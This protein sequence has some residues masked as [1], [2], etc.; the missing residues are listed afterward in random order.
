MLKRGIWFV[1]LFC[2]SLIAPSALAQTPMAVEV[3][4]PDGLV[5][6]G[7]WYPLSNDRPTILLLHQMYTNRTSWQPYIGI[8]TGAGYNVLAVDVRGHGQT[9]GK[10]D[11]AK[12]VDD[13]AVWLGW[14][15][16]AG[17]RDALMTMGSSM[18][19]TL[20]IVGCARDVT[21]RTA[22]AIS[23]GWSYNGISVEESLTTLLAG[24][25]VLILYTQRD[26][27][28]SRGVPRM[29]AA[30][31]QAVVVQMYTGNRHGMDLLKTWQDSLQVILNWLAAHSG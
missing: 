10:V 6:K 27:Y 7:D 12:A 4:A 11:W 19:S 25:Q 3:A 29:V 22:V 26:R 1:L 24:R 15:R 16:A 23:P 9:K 17:V 20:A 30:A 14:L 18:G 31:P 13:V 2:L 5:L 21:C 28:P 8:L